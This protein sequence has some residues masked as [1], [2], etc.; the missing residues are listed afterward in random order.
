MSHFPNID[1]IFKMVLLK[2]QIIK[3]MIALYQ[4]KHRSVSQKSAADEAELALH[5]QQWM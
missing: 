4:T 2:L 5:T 3:V 1:S